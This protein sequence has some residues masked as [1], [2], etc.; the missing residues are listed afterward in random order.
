MPDDSPI[1]N[2]FLQSGVY[3]G[4]LLWLKHRYTGGWVMVEQF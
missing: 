4:I 1:A 3:L 2:I